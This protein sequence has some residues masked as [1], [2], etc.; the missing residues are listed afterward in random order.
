MQFSKE[1]KMINRQFF[2]DHARQHLFGGSL[3]PGPVVGLTAV[4][5]YWEAN[6][7]KKDDRW[8]AYALATAHHETDRTFRGIE[9]YGKGRNKEYGKIDPETRVAY[10]GRGLVQLT[11]RNNY[12]KMGDL[13]GLDLVHHP[14]KALDIGIAT[15]VLFVGMTRGTFTGKKFSDYFAA[16]A[17]DWINARRIINGKDKA[18]LIAGY[19]KQYYAAISYT[20]G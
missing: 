20:T 4:L 16:D 9:E 10:Y 5:D 17:D 15:K 14:E 7:S 13:L 6:S 11:W 3:K 19:G 12:K 2:F 8:L 1:R 18:N